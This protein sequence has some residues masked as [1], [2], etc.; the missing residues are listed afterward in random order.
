[1][2]GGCYDVVGLLS[3]QLHDVLTQI[4]LYGFHVLLGEELVELDLFR[5]HR[6]GLHDRFGTGIS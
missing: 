6:L 5:R 2:L 3:K 1:M 4:S